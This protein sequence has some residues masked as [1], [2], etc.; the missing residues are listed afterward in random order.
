MDEDRFQKFLEDKYQKPTIRLYFERTREFDKWLFKQR[1]KNIDDADE[2]DIRSWASYIQKTVKKCQPYF[3][4]I[5]TYYRWRHKDQMENLMTEILRKLPSAQ[6]A[7]QNTIRW[8]DFES[9][10]MEVER[11][12][13][14][15]EYRVL[16]NLLWSEMKSEEILN[17]YVSDV[18]FEKRL[19]T[20][21]AGAKTFCVTHKA[22]RALEEYKP[23]DK[24][25]KVER[26]FS[27]GLRVLQ[28]TTQKYLGM[29]GL[30]PSKIRK[31]CL[32]DLPDTGRTIRFA[33]EPNK[34]V[35]SRIEHEQTEGSIS[36]KDLFDRLVEEIGNFGNR[37]HQRINQVKD[38][39]EFQRLLEGYLLATFPD[40][41]VTPEFPFK[42][43]GK[44]DSKI[45]FT[46]GNASK[47]PIEVKLAE[48]KFSEDIRKGSGQVNEF[49][50]HYGSSKGILVI[51]DKER[52]PE[53][54]KHSGIQDNVFIL[55]I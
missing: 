44:R 54:R 51:G 22:W 47:I 24:R 1:Q 14:S 40:E 50:K 15:L 17:L 39:H 52:D 41:L 27:K 21:P 8:K 45:D 13:I 53:R 23:V 6:K 37:M 20:S 43:F 46:I 30:T 11:T 49:L 18:D 32:D 55:V 28:H 48:K 10:M 25:G 19:I 31:S 4:G 42:G 34:E 38:E 3:S 2:S 29:H 33:A 26:L 35:V 36:Q 16:L 9:I 5:K 12:N 7:P